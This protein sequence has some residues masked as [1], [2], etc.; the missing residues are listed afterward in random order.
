[1]PLSER[2]VWKALSSG[3]TPAGICSTLPD[4]EWDQVK[5]ICSK[6]FL[7]YAT[8]DFC[9]RT[10]YQSIMHSL[11]AEHTTL[12]TRRDFAA[13]V[14]DANVSTIKSV[15]LFRLLNSWDISRQ[16]WEAIQPA[17]DDEQQTG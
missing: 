3:V 13:K 12:W 2:A 16:V 8:V 4:D 1:M 17:V 7:A 15:I 5:Q 11:T 6:I 10:M 14:M 9:S